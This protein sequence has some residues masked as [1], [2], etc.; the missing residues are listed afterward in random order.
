MAVSLLDRAKSAMASPGC[1]AVL[2]IVPLATVAARPVWATP[3]VLYG[4]ETVP[5]AVVP[6]GAINS[7][8]SDAIDKLTG[9][10]ASSPNSR[11]A[12]MSGSGGSGGFGGSGGSGGSG[13]FGGSGGS[14]GSFGIDNTKTGIY[15]K[16][17]TNTGASSNLQGTTQSNGFVHI[18]GSAGPFSG[19]NSGSLPGTVA[20]LSALDS[21]M[22][23]DLR[24]AGTL[25]G[26]T[27]TD[28][29]QLTTAL[30]AT[31]TGGTV[32]YQGMT[33][34]TSLGLDG[35]DTSNFPS[36]TGTSIDVLDTLASSP[37]AALGTGDGWQI[38]VFLD[39]NGFSPSS[40]LNIT[41]PSNSIDLGDQTNPV[42]EPAGLAL[43]IA[44]TMLLAR[45]RKR[46]RPPN[47]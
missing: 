16:S 34:S 6:G 47:G 8:S 40:Q 21:S 15:N 26:G 39:W 33:F 41:V 27:P 23:L 18:T 24:F 14:G 30:D 36:F 13:G 17:G 38:D 46:G 31:A 37:G 22:S 35:D 4:F 5:S 42:P 11:F 44:P 1:A 12:A 7:K 29:L 45:R 43:L 10:V 20:G 9:L 25:D 19:S 32:S 2:A 28:V 3:V